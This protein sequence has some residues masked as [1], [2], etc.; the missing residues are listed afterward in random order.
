MNASYKKATGRS[1]Q[2]QG[3]VTVYQHY[4]YDIFNS[5]IDFQVKELNSRFNDRTMK[6]LILSFALEPNDNFKL[7]KLVLFTSLLRNFILKILMNKRCII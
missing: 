7:L 2:Q 1:C 3:S 6:L 5:T 4:H